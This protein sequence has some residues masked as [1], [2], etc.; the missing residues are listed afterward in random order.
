VGDVILGLLL[1]GFFV[2]CYFVADRAGCYI[3][4][5][6]KNADRQPKQEDDDFLWR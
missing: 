2:L 5:L 1:I 6:R 4:E 3:D